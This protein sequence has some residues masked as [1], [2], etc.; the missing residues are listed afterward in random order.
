MFV[1]VADS[2]KRWRLRAGKTPRSLRNSPS[3]QTDA[4]ACFTGFDRRRRSFHAACGRDVRG[5]DGN[6]C[7]TPVPCVGEAPQTLQG[8][9]VVRR[10][11]VARW[12]VAAQGGR[13]RHSAGSGV[14]GVYIRVRTTP[15]ARKIGR[16]HV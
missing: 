5:G 6:G 1:V 8:L 14:A 13:T 3:G 15:Q 12:C 11:V 16:A 7:A 10:P 4:R 9:V 2:P